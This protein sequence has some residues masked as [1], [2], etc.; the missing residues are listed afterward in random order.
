MTRCIR[1]GEIGLRERRFDNGSF[2][3]YLS[4]W[5]CE[6]AFKDFDSYL[7]YWIDDRR[8]WRRVPTGCLLILSDF[9]L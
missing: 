9:G 6:A 1:C 2:G 4:C 7:E 3:S 5:R 8:G